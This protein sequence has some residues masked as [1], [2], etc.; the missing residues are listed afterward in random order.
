MWQDDFECAADIMAALAERGQHR[1]AKF[2]EF[3]LAA[4][5]G[6]TGLSI[7][8]C[9]EDFDRIAAVTGQAA[10]WIVPRGSVSVYRLQP[11]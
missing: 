8:H 5:A 4:V 2:P 10:E 6:R 9:D 11:R 3:L 7:L 1:A